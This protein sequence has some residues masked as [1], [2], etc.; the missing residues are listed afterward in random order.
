VTYGV[1]HRSQLLSGHDYFGDG[2]YEGARFDVAAAHA[3]WLEHRA[4]LLAYWT[5]PVDE[6]QRAG[7]FHGFATPQPPGPGHRP[8]AWWQFESPPDARRV[9]GPAPAN[10]NIKRAMGPSYTPGVLVES[11]PAYL[12]RHGLLTAE[13]SNLLAPSAFEPVRRMG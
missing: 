3:A 2:F 9:F 12:R 1:Q 4:E 11:E 10:P 5:M 7:Y 13:E 6:W 8:W